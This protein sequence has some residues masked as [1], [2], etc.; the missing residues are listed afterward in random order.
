M[1]D[2]II[3]SVLCWV[4]IY[5]ELAPYD[6]LMTAWILSVFAT[7][8]LNLIVMLLNKGYNDGV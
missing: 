6:I 5:L 4:A 8:T 1:R 3:V 2:I 7:G